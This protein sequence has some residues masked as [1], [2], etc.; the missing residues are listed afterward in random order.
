MAAYGGKVY[1]SYR[2][3]GVNGTAPTVTEDFVASADGGRTFSREYQAG[4]PSEIKWAAVS[5]EAPPPVAFY[6]DYMG[7]SAVRGKAEL[8]WAVSS[9][10]PGKEQYH[11]TLWGASIIP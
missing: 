5:D 3:R 6:G 11:Q 8:A 4:P 10:P 9:P 7:L 2:T 1:V